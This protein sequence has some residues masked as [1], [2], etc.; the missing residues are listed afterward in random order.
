MNLI[1]AQIVEATG[2]T[3]AYALQAI[4]SC[5]NYGFGWDQLSQPMIE[6]IVSLLDSNNLNVKGYS[7]SFMLTM[8]EEH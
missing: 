8:L 3:L 1:T 5:M 7:N 6:K 4:D 2:N